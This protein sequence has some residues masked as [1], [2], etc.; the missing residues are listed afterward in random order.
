ML[1]SKCCSNKIKIKNQKTVHELQEERRKAHER[2]QG[3]CKYIAEKICGIVEQKFI[4][5]FQCKKLE[6]YFAKPRGYNKDHMLNG[7]KLE[8]F[9]IGMRHC[10]QLKIYLKP[11]LLS[12]GISLD[13]F[14]ADHDTISFKVSLPQDPQD[15]QDPEDQ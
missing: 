5:H 11:S 10:N 13:S 9:V 1:F 14:W 4:T 7:L 15:P 2:E 6:I 3:Q 8:E 12:K